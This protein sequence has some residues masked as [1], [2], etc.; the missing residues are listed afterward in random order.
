LVAPNP[1]KE[2]LKAQ[3]SALESGTANYKVLS[4]EGKVIAKGSQRV[5]AGK[6]LINLGH[7]KAAAGN[8][9]LQVEAAGKQQQIQFNWN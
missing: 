2:L 1:S 8:Y 3:F 9:I 6:N 4:V 7:L 5:E